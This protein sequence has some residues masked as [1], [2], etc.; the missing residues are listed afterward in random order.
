[1]FIFILFWDGCN[2]LWFG[3]LAIQVINRPGHLKVR[4]RTPLC[5]AMPMFEFVILVRLAIMAIGFSGF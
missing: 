2:R 5:F 1:M 4:A 3:I